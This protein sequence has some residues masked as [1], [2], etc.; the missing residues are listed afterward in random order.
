MKDHKPLK[1]DVKRLRRAWR[2]LGACLLSAC[3]ST[4]SN[5]LKLYPTENTRPET[6]VTARLTRSCQV[7]D[8][9]VQQATLT[10]PDGEILEGEFR[11]LAASTDATALPQAPS[12]PLDVPA[13]VPGIPT[14]LPASMVVHGN[15]GSEMRC[16]MTISRNGRHG[17]GVCWTSNNK[18]FQLEF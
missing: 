16:E 11:M 3:A 18:I 9:R 15:G 1:P 14:G 7:G 8:C 12:G 17:A 2:L 6:M 13:P 5:D 10:M 4:A